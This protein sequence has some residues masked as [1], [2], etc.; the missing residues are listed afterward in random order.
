MATVALSGG[1]LSLGAARR[2]AAALRGARGA[3]G[4]A[5]ARRAPTTCAALRQLGDSDLHVSEICLGTM[6]WGKQNTEA[7]AHEQMTYAFA[8]GVNFMDTAEMYPVPTEAET[9][10]KTDLYI[11]TWLKQQKR[12]DVI[13]ASKVCGRSDRI[14]W[15]RGE[16]E[17]PSVTKQQVLWSVE[18]SLAR[19]QTDYIDLLQIHWPDRYV[20]L[21]GAS[22]YDYDNEI[23]AVSFEEQL[24]AMDTLITQGKIR[25]FG[26][27]NETSYGVMQFCQ[28]AREMGVARPVSIQNSYSLLVRTPFETD[29]A[30][31]CSPR[32]EHV[33]LL[34]YSPLA[35][36]SLSGKYIEKTP[37]GARFTLFP[38]YMERYNKSLAKEAVAEYV[39]VAEKHGLTSSEL[40]LLFCKDRQFVA[41]TIIG[42]TSMPQL[43]ENMGA[44]DKEFTAEMLE[45]ITKVYKKYR[46]PST[47][48]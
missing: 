7:E 43:K 19:L 28:K 6:T 34:A 30:E 2:P 12:E 16:G 48:V 35:G 13:L 22:A 11:G 1:A 17:T 26:L 29:L 10:G 42:A 3:R 39:K 27:S 44:F 5:A 23:D 24:E 36:G 25:A 21:F 40:A 9:Q 18:Q 41:S 33:G 8:N 32:N 37:E 38:G 47:S 31:V 15:I 4:V 20:P 14:T 45:D 46:D